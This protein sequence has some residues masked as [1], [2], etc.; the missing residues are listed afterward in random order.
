MQTERFM[1]G[2]LTIVIGLAYL[3]SWDCRQ[4]SYVFLFYKV[5]G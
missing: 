1:G 2:K 4:T 3:A 5:N